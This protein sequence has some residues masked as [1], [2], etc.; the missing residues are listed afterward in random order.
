M[1]IKKG[2]SR[3][4][5]RAA[6]IWGIVMFLTVPLLFKLIFSPELLAPVFGSQWTHRDGTE[7]TNW[8]P[9]ENAIKCVTHESYHRDGATCIPSDTR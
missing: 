7:L 2:W 9:T 6:L 1:A 5:F 4:Q 3:K 8:P